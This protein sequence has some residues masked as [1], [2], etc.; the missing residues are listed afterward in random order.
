M[1]TKVEEE[2]QRKCEQY[3]PEQGRMQY[4]GPLR[5]TLADQQVFADYTIRTLHIMVS[6]FLLISSLTTLRA[7]SC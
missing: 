2:G 3:W 4:V 1:L 6:S 7:L 5:V